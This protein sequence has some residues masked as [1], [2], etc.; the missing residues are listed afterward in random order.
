MYYYKDVS[1][2]K[3]LYLQWFQFLK[4]TKRIALWTRWADYKVHMENKHARIAWWD[5]EI[6]G[7]VCEDIK[8]YQILWHNVVS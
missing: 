8:H 6:A 3:A 1:S 5:G 7:E 4:H 2:H